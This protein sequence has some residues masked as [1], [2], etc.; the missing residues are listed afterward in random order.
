MMSRVE[1]KLCT[2]V[3]AALYSAYLLAITPS[4][5]TERV[6]ITLE[7]L[8][9]QRS[10]H[11]TVRNSK[12]DRMKKAIP[13]NDEDVTFLVETEEP[14]QSPTDGGKLSERNLLPEGPPRHDP[15]GQ[16]P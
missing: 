8:L 3:A 14:H 11:T 13:K 1:F 2:K 9:S 7:V 12:V 4:S 15:V 10:F 16:N 6:Q 5:E